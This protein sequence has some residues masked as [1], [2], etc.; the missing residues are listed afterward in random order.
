MRR[1]ALAAI[2]FAGFVV[3]A[4]ALAQGRNCDT[5]RELQR[6]TLATLKPGATPAAMQS[7]IENL[8][9]ATELCP[10]LGDAYYFLSLLAHEVKDEARAGN[11]RTKAEFYESAALR[12]GIPLHG[13]AQTSGV[14]SV[15][16]TISATVLP[17]TPGPAPIRV[18]PVVRQK[19]ALI[20]GVSR[21]KDPRINSLKYTSKDAQ[22]VAVALE[23]QGD[24][25]Y[26]KTLLDEDATLYN[27]KTELERLA[28][29][30]TKDDLVVLYVSSH[31]SPED[32][33]TAGV[34]YIVTHDTEVN[35]LYP[36]AYRMDDL[37]DD[38]GIRIK[39]ERV[40]AFLDTCFSGGT[41]RELPS[42]WVASSRSLQ[43]E[44]GVVA[45]RLEAR[46]MRDSRALVVDDGSADNKDRMPQGVGR[47]IIVSSEQAER[48]WEDDRIQHGY[49]TYFLLEALA[50]QGPLSVDDLY[51]HLRLRVPEA[52]LRDKKEAQ[53]PRIAR[54]KDRVD[55]YLK[56][57]RSAPRK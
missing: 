13:G 28:K 46:L 51:A 11:W 53:H 14:T 31:G 27:V 1:A 20:V 4:A 6:S 38:I 8:R 50:R 7:A 35:N 19:L 2:V 48:S 36:T 3:P 24:F 18:S 9:R 26:V 45:S 49:F 17:T 56:D 47:V 5:A 57:R 52:V 42:G 15:T 44:S 55:L 16:P 37:L 41:F 25:D 21:F 39:A 40:V 30:A 34:N 33:D 29:M 32:L 22:A 43:S 12:D 54:S 23:R 10:G